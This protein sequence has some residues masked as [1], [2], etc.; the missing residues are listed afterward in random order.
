VTAAEQAVEVLNDKA[1]V[2]PP[3]TVM[4]PAKLFFTAV[5]G[6]A[7]FLGFTCLGHAQGWL[8]VVSVA[9]GILGMFLTWRLARKPKPSL[10]D[11]AK[12][13]VLLVLIA[14]LPVRL[15]VQ[16]LTQMFRT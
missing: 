11:A 10:V 3:R 2:R 7:S 15:A 6:V 1:F 13:V 4:I 9:C 16:V 14:I 8:D 5:F 12:L